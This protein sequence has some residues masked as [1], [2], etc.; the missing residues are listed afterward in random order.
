M[1]V[2]VRRIY[3]RRDT[4]EGD[5]CVCSKAVKR[6]RTVARSPADDV[7]HNAEITGS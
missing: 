3:R 6:L 4:H 1:T 5:Q 2:T 7:E